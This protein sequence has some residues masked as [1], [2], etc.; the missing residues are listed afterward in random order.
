MPWKRQAGP[1][2]RP[3]RKTDPWKRQPLLLA[4]PPQQVAS[5]QELKE[6]LQ[7]ALEKAKA[8]AAAAT[9][10]GDLVSMPL[11]Q[12]LDNAL[13]KA[14]PVILQKTDPIHVCVDW[15]DTL[16]KGEVISA[17]NMAAL[18][19]LLQVCKVH[20]ISSVGS[21]WRKK[22][23]LKD[24]RDLP[25]FDKLASHHAIMVQT[26][27]GGKVDWACYLGCEAIFDD[28]AKIIKEGKE[29][30]LKTYPIQGKTDHQGGGCWATF[31]DAVL[32]FLEHNSK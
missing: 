12:Q 27:V 7:K 29:W 16:E 25:Q 5:E 30:G 2:G 32:D 20:I 6:Q 15:H 28:Q 21:N 1:T 17:E 11:V 3:R 24:I 13:E 31:A 4:Q 9:A 10:A 19:C 18:N 23:V 26:G 22:Q 14:K 8:E